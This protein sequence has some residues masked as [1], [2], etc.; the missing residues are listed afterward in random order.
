MNFWISWLKINEKTCFLSG[1][2]V[3]RRGL[4]FGSCDKI[5]QF[6]GQLDDVS[7]NRKHVICLN[8]I[9]M[10]CNLQ[11]V[12]YAVVKKDTDVNGHERLFNLI[13]KT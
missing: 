4:T 10:P 7:M 1:N 9:D 8:W 2:I 6:K 12:Y 3:P 11:N 5:P 13:T